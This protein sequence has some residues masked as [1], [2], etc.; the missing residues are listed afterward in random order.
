LTSQFAKVIEVPIPRRFQK[1]ALPKL[2]FDPEW[3]AI[4]RAFHPY[5][6]TGYHQKP[7]PNESQARQMVERELEWVHQHVENK[8]TMDVLH[9]QQFTTTAPARHGVGAPPSPHQRKHLILKKLNAMHWLDP[10]TLAAPAY[11]NPQT[12]ALCRLLGIQNKI[13][14]DP[15]TGS[16]SP[17]A[18]PSS[19]ASDEVQIQFCTEDR[20]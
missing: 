18:P 14:P 13:N 19:G 11:S 20:S 15:R 16:E 12:E 6:S 5:F 3:L 9:C 10:F 17:V 4:T 8:G 1:E 2:T 7:F